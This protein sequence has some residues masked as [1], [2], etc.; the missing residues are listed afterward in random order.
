MCITKTLKIKYQKVTAFE[1]IK[2]NMKI[3]IQVWQ[4]GAREKVWRKFVEGGV[5]KWYFGLLLHALKYI[6]WAIQYNKALFKIHCARILVNT[7]V[8]TIYTCILHWVQSSV[9]AY[10]VFKI[11][12]GNEQRHLKFI[13]KKFKLAR[14]TKYMY[15]HTY[16]LEP[17]CF[18]FLTSLK[19]HH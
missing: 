11:K 3:C 10:I 2:I 15:M 5:E 7:F 14:K 18:C 4:G 17:F 8:F 13:N 12:T 19:T 9:L 16:H 6:I 1:S